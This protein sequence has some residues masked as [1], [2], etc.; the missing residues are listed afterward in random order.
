MGKGI[1]KSIFSAGA[2]KLVSSI[3]DAIDKNITSKE[4]RLQLRKEI[5]GQV[6]EYNSDMEGLAVRN[7]ESAR[8]MQVA[9]LQQTDKFS[10]RFI[11]YLAAFW[12]LV[13]SGY[14]F[15]ATYIP[16]PADNQS[17]ADTVLGFLLGTLVAT[18]IN[19]FFGSSKGSKDK[20]D[21][22]NLQV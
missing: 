19:Y 15:A 9:A 1:L 3:G 10:K 2:S 4:E 18:I 21:L 6:L 16:I 14:I 12:S 17:L 22:L 8:L 20:Q 13:G 11:Y 7:T 5:E